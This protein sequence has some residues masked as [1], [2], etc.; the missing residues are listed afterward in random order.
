MRTFEFSE[1]GLKLTVMCVGYSEAHHLKFLHLAERMQKFSKNLV[2]SL[3]I[4]FVARR[5]QDGNVAF[6]S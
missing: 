4:L 6:F 2:K 1:A 3:W 5:A